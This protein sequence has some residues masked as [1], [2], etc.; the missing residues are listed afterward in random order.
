MQFQANLL[1]YIKER[2]FIIIKLNKNKGKLSRQR[3]FVEEKY[4]KILLLT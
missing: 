4:S 2:I 1:S 3:K